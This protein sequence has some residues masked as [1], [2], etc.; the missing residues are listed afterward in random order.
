MRPFRLRTK[1]VLWVAVFALMAV[2]IP[3]IAAPPGTSTFTFLQADAHAEG[4]HPILGE[5]TAWFNAND[6]GGG[7]NLHVTI[8]SND[9]FFQCDFDG[10]PNLATDDGSTL[11]LGIEDR[12]CEGE[13]GD[14]FLIHDLISANVTWTYDTSRVRSH[15]NRTGEQCKTVSQEDHSPVVSIDLTNDQF[16]PGGPLLDGAGSNDARY[17]N[18]EGYC[19]ATGS[20]GNP[21]P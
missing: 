14:G 4:N 10:S 11:T 2:S 12:V 9:G 1:P 17:I 15:T 21:H 20:P 6:D 8:A 13:D 18:G 5:F 3:A 7:W 16:D 19:H